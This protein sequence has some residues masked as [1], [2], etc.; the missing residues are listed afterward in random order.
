MVNKIEKEV[1]L[2]ER[3]LIVGIT[4]EDISHYH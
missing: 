4:E 3:I 2:V 1:P